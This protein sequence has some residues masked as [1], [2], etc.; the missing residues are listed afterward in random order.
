MSEDED[1]HGGFG[2]ECAGI[3]LAK[4]C[5]INGVR[6]RYKACIESVAMSVVYHTNI[7]NL[8]HVERGQVAYKH[9][10]DTTQHRC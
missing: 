7:R 2:V 1:G 9:D 8:E 6:E 4:T 3:F 5:K 10:F